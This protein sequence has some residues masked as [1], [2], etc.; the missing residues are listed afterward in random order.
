[1]GERMQ[2]RSCRRRF[3]ERN[4]VA[5]M[6]VLASGPVWCLRSARRGGALASAAALHLSVRVG[7]SSGTAPSSL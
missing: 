5:T 7:A 6:I 3:V 1:M 4:C 2:E